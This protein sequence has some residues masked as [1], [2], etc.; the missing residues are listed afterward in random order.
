MTYLRKINLFARGIDVATIRRFALVVLLMIVGHSVFE[1][2]TNILLKIGSGPHLPAHGLHWV[3][4]WFGVWFL[5]L[6]AWGVAI[7][8]S[9]VGG[10]I[11]TG[12][13]VWFW[14]TAMIALGVL[15]L[16][17]QLLTTESRLVFSYFSS[18]TLLASGLA[19][20]V[21]NHHP[22]V[23][24]L[25]SLYLSAATHKLLNFSK[26][27]EQIPELVGPELSRHL[28]SSIDFQRGLLGFMSFA[29]VPVEYVLGLALIFPRYRRAGFLLALVFHSM[30]A[31]G[32]NDGMGLGFVGFAVLYAHFLL[33]LFFGLF[34]DEQDSEKDISTSLSRALFFSAVM[35]GG[36]YFLIRGSAWIG[37]RWVIG[38]YLPLA[39]LYVTVFCSAARSSSLRSPS[40]KRSTNYLWMGFLFLWFVYPLALGY[41]N[42]Q[43]GWA[44]FSGAA[45]DR[46]A[47]CIA[48]V[49]SSCFQSWRFFPQVRMLQT[50]QGVVF[51][52]RLE[53]HLDTVRSELKNRCALEASPIGLLKRT[54]GRMECSTSE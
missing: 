16:L 48:V 23:I 42:Q 34:G 24:L 1:S 9:L 54:D 3:S 46:A 21:R 35:G 10:L 53:S 6:L 13:Y 2:H 51:V 29:V 47:H 15:A 37:A 14:G 22:L 17:L 27:L 31:I 41:R 4:D 18:F 39:A 25:S 33:A 40:F 19:C 32:T 20:R 28:I 12:R 43:F 30:L 44:M 36:A 52:A 8:L 45:S 5:F 11:I 49:E 38:L 50:V 7:G 26:M